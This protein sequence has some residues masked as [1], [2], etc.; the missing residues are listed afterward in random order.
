M[1]GINGGEVLVLLLII[2][3]VVGPR[4]LPQ[5]AEQL[6]RWTRQ[7][8]AF[9]T[10]AKVRVA[11]EMGEEAAAVDWET[12]DPRRYD[13]RR[14]VREALADDGVGPVRREASTAA[15]A[16]AGASVPSAASS[17]DGWSSARSAAAAPS[18][19]DAPLPPVDPDLT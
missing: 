10:D 11:Q 19:G 5:Y 6:G 4:R 1:F 3:I 13:P 9:V 8:R 15:R 14:I 12:L 16:A 2:V 18:G 7:L 17:S